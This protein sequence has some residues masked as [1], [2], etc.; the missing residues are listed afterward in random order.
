MCGPRLGYPSVQAIYLD[1]QLSGWTVVNNT[2]IDCQKGVFVGGGRN[3]W[4]AGNRFFNCDTAV[5]LDNRGA[6]L[7]VF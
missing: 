1:D 7:G 2:F 3:T 4:V 6:L 5:H